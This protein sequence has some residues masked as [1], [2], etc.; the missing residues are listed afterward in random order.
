[1]A[2]IPKTLRKD[3]I[4]GEMEKRQEKAR[5]YKIGPSYKKV[6]KDPN[7][8]DY[9]THIYMPIGIVAL[10]AACM[11]L[12]LGII[13]KPIYL[14]IAT[15]FWSAGYFLLANINANIKRTIK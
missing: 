6:D 13:T 2:V 4:P 11:L 9:I 3:V 7:L 10:I 15:I 5:G 12:L 8:D 1:M 14:A